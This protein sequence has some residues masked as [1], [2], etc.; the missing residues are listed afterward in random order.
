MNRGFLQT[1]R[2]RFVTKDSFFYHWKIRGH[3]ASDRARMLNDLSK[4]LPQL[5][6]LVMRLS[7]NW[8][9]KKYCLSNMVSSVVQM[10]HGAEPIMLVVEWFMCVYTRTLPWASAL[11]VLD[12]FFCE[13]A[14][15]SYS[16][17]KFSPR[18]IIVTYI[19]IYAYNIM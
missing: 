13:G 7:L 18:S 6:M 1:L 12:M 9:I 17:K 8:L 16:S 14:T 19:Y 10:N 11:R 5:R 15:I 3:S 4:F 2:G